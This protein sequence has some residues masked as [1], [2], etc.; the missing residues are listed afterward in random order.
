[1][2]AH[3][4]P[5]QR[6]GMLV[7]ALATA[8]LLLTLPDKSVTAQ[9]SGGPLYAVEVNGIVTAPT[10]DYLRR[11]VQIAEASSADALIISYSSTG[12][13]LREVRVF[14]AEIVQARVPIVVFIT[15]R[16]TQAGP[17]GAIFV[18]AAHVSALAPDTSFGSPFPLAQVDETLSQQT[19]D[20]LLDNVS[21]QMKKWNET[22]GRNADWI[23]RAVREGVILNNQQAI[24]LDP[25]AV[26][27]VAADQREL[28]TLL[29]GRTV[30]LDDGRTVRI[31]AL[32]RTPTLIEPTLFESLRLA[33]A[34]PTVAFALLVLG[35]MAIYLELNTPGVGLFA[36]AGLVLL[37]GAAAGFLVLPIVWWGMT[38]VILGLVLIGAEFVAPTHGG[39][40]ITGLAMLGVGGGNLIDATQAP[41]AGVAWWAL[42]IVVGG[43]AAT[44][45]AGLALALRSRK[46]P[47]ATGTEALIGRL[48]QVRRRLD[49][50]GMVF[51]EGALWQAI[52]ES[53]PVEVGDWVRVVAVHN[54]QLIVRPLESEEPAPQEAQPPSGGR[55]V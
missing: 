35:S 45:A 30:T 36:G 1:M 14:A 53:E 3:C 33:L 41:G 2:P 12:G 31:S 10:I 26:D 4:S 49:P 16:G 34:D 55:V 42:L 23:D 6:S 50:R 9:Q 47:A 27:L 44:A 24:S 25:P 54:L 8:L 13:V 20:L 39:L 38:L 48:A 17:A 46:R 15:P 21:A 11:A 28:L 52:S 43:I 7:V 22:R 51:V 19:R 29:E 18:T 5:Y 40:M 32:G 37:L